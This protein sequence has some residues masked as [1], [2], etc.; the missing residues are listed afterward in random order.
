MRDMTPRCW[1]LDAGCLMLDARYSNSIPHL[2]HGFQASKLPVSSFQ[3]VYRFR[4][5]VCMLLA[6]RWQRDGPINHLGDHRQDPGVGMVGVSTADTG[7]CASNSKFGFRRAIFVN[8]HRF[9]ADFGATMRAP[10]AATWLAPDDF[11][12]CSAAH[13]AHTRTSSPKKSTGGLQA[14]KS[15]PERPLEAHLCRL[16]RPV[17]GIR[18]RPQHPTAS[19]KSDLELLG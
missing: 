16:A 5:K 14:L 18:G 9:T 15:W 3:L 1:K 19:L 13:Q 10:T 2:V 8:V 11:D 6:L 7:T 12:L 17:A 4:L